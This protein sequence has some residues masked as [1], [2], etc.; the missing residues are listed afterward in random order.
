MVAKESKPFLVTTACEEFWDT[1]KE[2]VFLGPWCLRFSRRSFWE[3]LGENT[4]KSPWH[5]PSSVSAASVRMFELYEYF[6]PRLVGA[7]NSMHGTHHDISYWRLIIG[8]WLQFYLPVVYDRY[9]S[10]K[11]AIAEYPD[12]TTTVLAQESFVTPRNTL[13]FAQLIKDDPYNLQIYSRIFQFMGQELP[14]HK[15]E[16]SS[17]SFS[18]QEWHRGWKLKVKKNVRCCAV[19]LSRFFS[20]GRRVILRDSYFS[21]GIELSLILQ[22]FGRVWPIIGNPEDIPRNKIDSDKRSKLF[23]IEVVDDDFCRLISALIPFD[24]PACFVEDFTAI[25]DSAVN[26]YPKNTTAIFSTIAWYYDEPFKQWAATSREKGALLLG[27]QHGGNYGSLKHHPCEDHEI[28]ITDRYYTWGWSKQAQNGKV[29]PFYSTKFSGRKRIG[30]T[31]EKNI[32]LYATTSMPR[33]LSQFPFHPD[34]FVEYLGWQVRFVENLSYA[35]RSEVRIRLHREDMG[36]DMRER[37]QKNFPDV[38]IEGWDIPFMERLKKSR[39]YVCDH[40]STTFLEALAADVPTILFWSSDH[41]ELRREA[42]HLYDQ[43]REAGILYDTPEL[44]AK[45]VTEAYQNVENWWNNQKR[46]AACSN[47]C[48]YYARTSPAIGGLWATEF[49]D[50]MRR[51]ATLLKMVT[52]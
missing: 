42:I 43:L 2:L 25:A 7:L 40:L 34:Q 31:Q 49:G 36:W 19:A 44:A 46:M 23:G 14:S 22:T 41:N 37:W 5:N 29:I 1:T 12:F 38:T 28:G 17:A 4:I 45:A 15:H 39:L 52:Y 6:L 48:D 10:L 47:F 21:P 26:W 9:T 30:A 51:S 33:Y 18:P 27:M 50:I 3:K 11:K 32:I 24:I 35:L 8:P 16:F 20:E 13:E